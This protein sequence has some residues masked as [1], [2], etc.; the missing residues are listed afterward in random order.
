MNDFFTLLIEQI[1]SQSGLEVVAVITAIGYV[2]LAARQS[3]WCW[4]CALVSTG[5]YVWLF[6]EVSLP[7]HIFLNAYYLVMAVYGWVKWKGASNEPLQVVS[8]SLLT[9]AKWTGLV[10]ILALGISML[11]ATQLDPEY[12]YLDAFVTVFSLFATVLVAH[13]VLE[14]W[15][16][17][18]VINL[19]A[20]YLYFEKGLAL[21]SCLFV[22]YTV[23]AIYGYFSWRKHHVQSMSPQNT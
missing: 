7:F 20:S 1:T 4:P 19:F 5:I 18:I 2:W 21:T 17:W 9:H 23:F 16:Y 13:K 10:F 3:I 6:W 8:W 22:L 11:A 12:V 15:L 14:N